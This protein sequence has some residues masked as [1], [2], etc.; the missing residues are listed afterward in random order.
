[1]T[2]V[3]HVT[4]DVAGG[5]GRAAQ[6][7]HEAV[8]LAGIDST[9]VS[10]RSPQDRAGGRVSRTMRRVYYGVRGRAEAAV[11]GLMKPPHKSPRWT[12]VIPSQW[13]GFVNASNYDIVHLHWVCGGM[14]SIADI[15]RFRKPVV[16]TMHDMWAF[17]GSEHVAGDDRFSVGYLASTR[18]P[19]LR[20]FDLD[21]W[22]WERKRRCWTSEFRIVA[23]SH[24]MAS[25]VKRSALMGRWEVAVVPNP[26][27]TTIWSPPSRSSARAALGIAQDSAVLCV[28][29][30]DGAISPHKGYDLLLAALPLIP[31]I[32]PLVVFVVG[33][34]EGWRP[35]IQGV[36]FRFLGLVADD[37]VL[38]QAY[39]ASDATVVPSRIDNLPNTAVEAA[40]CGL[41]IA[42]FAIGGLPDIVDHGV[43][44]YLAEPFDVGGLARAISW[45]LGRDTGPAAGVAGRSRAVERF[46]MLHVGRR[47]A[48]VYQAALQGRGTQI[49]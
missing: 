34:S 48:D 13:A 1:M 44:G 3:L 10:A 14:I 31:A 41:P 22:T 39:A 43:S 33:R 19:G 11:N 47:Y 9:L 18:P 28:V 17:C 6:R 2:K 27:D 15:G 26:I 20:G 12:A 35:Q 30:I 38:R 37:E 49:A 8:S 24:W 4:Y 46:G 42:A 23:P 36:E 16:W 29:G 5:A 21:A 7:I 25:C 45:V 32:G 40:S